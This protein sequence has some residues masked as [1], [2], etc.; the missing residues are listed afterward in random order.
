MLEN[1]RGY[2]VILASGSPR[3]KALLEGLG[4]P[5]RII[6]SH[7]DESVASDL[8]PETAVRL[9]S[10]R[11]AH[12]VLRQAQ[13]NSL[14][15]AADTI[16]YIDNEIIGKPADVAEAMM[17]LKKLSGRWHDVMTGVTLL[18]VAY[19]ECF[20]VQSSV[21]FMP[22]TDEEILHYVEQAKPLD[23]AGAYG[24]QEWIG[25]VGIAEIRGSFY[26]VMG[27]PTSRLY[28][29]LKKVP[30]YAD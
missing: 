14:C 17:M 23:K 13:A 4:V 8:E 21:R 11:K 28:A 12:A 5:F 30:D 24:I 20:S 10:Q 15:I 25:L 9:I 29:E 16:V 3:R 22:L 27:L 18:G 1:L 7:A 2:D 19:E 6:T 26:N